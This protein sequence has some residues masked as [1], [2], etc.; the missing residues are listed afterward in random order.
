M[1]AIS[2]PLHRCHFLQT[3][4]LPPPPYLFSPGQKEV[5]YPPIICWN[6]IIIQRRRKSTLGCWFFFFLTA[7]PKKKLA[8]RNGGKINASER[9]P[10]ILFS[11]SAPHSSFGREF[12][13]PGRAF[14]LFFNLYFFTP[15]C[16]PPILR[17]F[18]PPPP[19]PSPVCLSF[20]LNLISDL[21]CLA[22][23]P[24]AMFS[25]RSNANAP[26]L[27]VPA[28]RPARCA[29]I[30]KKKNMAWL[31]SKGCFLRGWA[32]LNLAACN[33]VNQPELESEESQE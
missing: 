21:F 25:K 11:A 27:Q 6:H 17:L 15:S 19:S 23:L 9:D 7:S 32:V 5:C 13:K 2:A 1:A 29:V 28:E 18:Q 26:F 12:T 33:I 31:V 20:K 24:L 22:C 14:C 3:N 16:Q 10:H 4:R 30:R 8:E